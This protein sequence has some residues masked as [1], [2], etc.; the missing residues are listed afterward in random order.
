[1]KLMEATGA[2]A[3]E[4]MADLFDPITDIASDGEILACINTNQQAKAIKFA[5]KRHSKAL[6]EIMAICEGV[7]V[8]EYN[9]NAIE[10][11]RDITVVMNHPMIAELF[12]TQAS[13]SEETSSGKPT[14]NTEAGEQ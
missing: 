8:E 13:Q 2:E 4:M 6:A 9:K 5:M 7:P 10:M 3:F 14:E 12:F 1:M 11:L